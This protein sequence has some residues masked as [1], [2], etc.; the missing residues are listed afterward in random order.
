MRTAIVVTL[1]ALLFGPAFAGARAGEAAGEV[2][3]LAARIK[4]EK[5]LVGEAPVKRLGEI[6]TRPAMDALVVAYDAMDTL[7]MRREVLRA[8]A[9]YDGLADC[10]QAALQKI[11]DAATMEDAREL[12]EAALKLLGDAEHLGKHF[13]GIIIDSPAEDSVRAKAMEYYALRYDEKEDYK[14]FQKLFR[15]ADEDA[16]KLKPKKQ[17]EKEP[18]LAIFVLPKIRELALEKIAPKMD[19]DELV[20]NARKMEKDLN[21]IPRDGV[22]R[23]AL[24]EL[25][26]R[27]DKRA[28]DLARDAYKSVTERSQ[29]RALAAEIMAKLDGDK[30]ATQF[31]DD[32]SKGPDVMPA[33]VRDK[34]ADL[35]GAWALDP[36]QKALMPKLEK[37]LGAKAS[38]SQ[39]CFALRALAKLG[40]DKVTKALAKALLDADAQVQ[41]AACDALARRDDKSVVPDVEKLLSTSKRADVQGAAMDAIGALRYGEGD[42]LAKLEIDAASENAEIR[43]AALWQLAKLAQK[44]FMPL[45]VRSLEH[46]EWSTRLAALRGLEI[47]GGPDAIE[48]II[49]RMGKEE[50]RLR[51]EFCDAL[52]RLTGQTLPPEPGAWEKWWVDAKSAFKPLGTGELWRLQQEEETR[53]LT[54]ATKNTF[55]GMRIVS[56][57]VIFI[58]DVSG[59]MKEETRS[60]YLGKPGEPR[61]EVAKRELIK[62]IDALD[63][64]ALFNMIVFSDGVDRWLDEGVAESKDKERADAKTFVS[65]LGANGGTNLFGAVQ[66]A[67]AD[68]E[69]DTIYIMSDGEPSVGDV[70]DPAEIRRQVARWNEHRKIVIHTIAVGGSFQ[71]LEW[72][73]ADSG[74]T[75]V[76]FD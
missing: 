46:A 62:C 27:G 60:P 63:K 70:R 65:R 28:I 32:G 51:R 42:W 29:N 20:D 7:Y 35:V 12:R 69:V 68:P 30:L 36:K 58:I 1:L 25:D 72:L 64:D 3:D 19:A 2:E 75:H 71:V 66:S 74:G 11:T 40:D 26:R 38:S 43:N 6:G 13:L 5:D 49:R 41:I 14:F 37:L 67:F 50:G 56:H 18:Q 53:R 76:K 23:L 10:E 61:M 17:R 34:L 4:T 57:R 16:P 33:D 44:R 48:T 55:Y 39:K 8:L 15:Q 31:I 21:D 45:Y 59:S 54:Q 24:M 52:F 9:K 73:A 47:L 22:R